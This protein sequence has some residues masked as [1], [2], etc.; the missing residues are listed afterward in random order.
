M[1]VVLD[2][3]LVVVEV[4]SCF[5]VVVDTEELELLEDVGL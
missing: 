5:E 4:G 3:A 2:G 1:V